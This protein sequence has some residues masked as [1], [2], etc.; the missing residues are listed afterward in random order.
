[1]SKKIEILLVKEGEMDISVTCFP[2]ITLN[3]FRT[4][5]ALR[6]GWPALD[7][8]PKD[9][10][11][12]GLD[13]IFILGIVLFAYMGAIVTYI[14][15]VSF[16]IVYFIRTKYYTWNFIQN[17]ID[18]G[19]T[20]SEEIKPILENAGINFDGIDKSVRKGIDKIFFKKEKFERSSRRNI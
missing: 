19:Y 20:I 4:L 8:N 18:R 3:F 10:K 11:G 16:Y 9:W 17:K 1:M 15:A 6:Y 12:V 5:L 13:I 7:V 2:K 14:I